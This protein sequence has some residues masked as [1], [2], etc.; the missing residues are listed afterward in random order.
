MVRKEGV[1]SINRTVAT[2]EGALDTA[3]GT[4]T[5]LGEQGDRLHRT[6]EFPDS[7]QRQNNRC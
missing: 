3:L 7:Y 6:Y 4:Y 2:A 1:A 5:R